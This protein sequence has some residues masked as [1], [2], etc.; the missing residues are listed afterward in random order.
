MYKPSQYVYTERD[1]NITI[2]LADA[3][4]KQYSIKFFEEN[5]TELF[6]IKHVKEA[7][8]TLDKANFLHAGW[9]CL[10]CMKKGN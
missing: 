2:S 3:N 4:K 9:F 8:L 5:E 7:L 6:E 1:G 10:N